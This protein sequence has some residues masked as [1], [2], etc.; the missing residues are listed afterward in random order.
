MELF[1]SYSKWTHLFGYGL[2][3]TGQARA[4]SL[5]ANIK[6]T[7]TSSNRGHAISSKFMDFEGLINSEYLCVENPLTHSNSGK[8]S[9]EHVGSVYMSRVFNSVSNKTNNK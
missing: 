7:T 5:Y 2:F 8:L 3:E 9:N 6:S 4:S 1:R